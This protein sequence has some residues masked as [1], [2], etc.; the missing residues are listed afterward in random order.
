MSTFKEKKDDKEEGG[1]EEKWWA[2]EGTEVVDLT[3]TEDEKAGMYNKLFFL[4]PSCLTNKVR[5]Y[6]AKNKRWVIMWEIQREF[7]DLS[8]KYCKRVFHKR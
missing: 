1:G 6:D 7:R 4:N 8:C 2:K 5:E 3:V